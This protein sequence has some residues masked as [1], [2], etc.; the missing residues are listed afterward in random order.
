MVRCGDT[1][2]YSGGLP[3]FSEINPAATRHR[4]I[5]MAREVTRVQQVRSHQT[6]EGEKSPDYG[7]GEVTRL[8]GVGP[9]DK[10]LYRL[11]PPLA[12]MVWDWRWLEDLE[13][14]GDLL[15]ELIGNEAQCLPE[16]RLTASVSSLF[17][18]YQS[19]G[20]SLNLHWLTGTIQYHGLLT[21]L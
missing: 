7:S 12:F 9:V 6:T 1:G 3:T 13:E 4:N 11:A 10:T 19:L 5:K 18:K 14:K 16:L 20:F 15:N 8:D 21:P 17:C 2:R